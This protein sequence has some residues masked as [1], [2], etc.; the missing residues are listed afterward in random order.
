MQEGEKI[1]K[2]EIFMTVKPRCKAKRKRGLEDLAAG[3]ANRH[4]FVLDQCVF[5]FFLSSYSKKLLGFLFFAVPVLPVPVPVK[6]HNRRKGED[7][8]QDRHKSPTHP[9]VGAQSATGCAST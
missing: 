5:S 6:S 8:G 4:A 9:V 1:E 3:D 7:G 2:S